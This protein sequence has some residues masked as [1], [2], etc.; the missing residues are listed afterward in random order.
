MSEEK[1]EGEAARRLAGSGRKMI[2][3]QHRSAMP[4]TCRPRAPGELVTLV[5]PIFLAC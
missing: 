4:V 2:T 3:L 1:E 5:V